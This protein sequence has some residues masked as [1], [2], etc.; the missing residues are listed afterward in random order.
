MTKL[1]KKAT[2]RLLDTAFESLEDVVRDIIK[3]KDNKIEQLEDGTED[4]IDPSIQDSEKYV[5]L[6]KKSFK[7]FDN[8]NIPLLEI[9][10]YLP[11]EKL[12]DIADR[13]AVSKEYKDY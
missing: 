5:I 7:S 8:L 6:N 4:L 3:D 11:Y 13:K 9:I 12:K 2:D 1:T 10:M